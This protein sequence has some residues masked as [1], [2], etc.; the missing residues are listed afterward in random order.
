MVIGPKHEVIRRNVAMQDADSVKVIDRVQCIPQGGPEHVRRQPLRLVVRYA[1]HVFAVH[2]GHRHVGRI[3]FLEDLMHLH[4]V[5]M[6]K[7]RHAAG[8]AQKVL[9]NGSELIGPFGRQRIDLASRPATKC[10]GEAFLYDVLP[11][12]GI[13]GQIRDAKATTHKVAL[14][15]VLAEQKCS[16]D[17]QFILLAL[18]F[19]NAVIEQGRQLSI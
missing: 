1:Q 18:L 3:V 9:E 14:D 19:E 2:I 15:P 10:A 16:A 11:V 4:D 13:M 6:A 12:E 7:P 8:L 5:G 17:G